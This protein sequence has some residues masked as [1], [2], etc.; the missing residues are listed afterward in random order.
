MKKFVILAAKVNLALVF[1]FGVFCGQAGANEPATKPLRASADIFSCIGDDSIVGSA[2]LRES[3]S[4][5]GIK[6]VDIN[7]IVMG[8]SE[9]QHAVHIHQTAACEISCGATQGHFD[10]GPNSNTNPDGNH[11][12]H[13][14]DLVN[15]EV[16]RGVGVM[17]TRT[18]RITL[19]PGPLSI[20]DNDG[21]AFIIHVNPDTY[22]PNGP[23]AGCA[24]GARAAC[25]NIYLD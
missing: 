21:S 7:M 22:C 17:R 16:N 5:E 12:F 11:P 6:Q 4:T 25:G 3:K 10:P 20:F 19:S 8:L 15:I 18:N 1:L 24:G 23:E 2:V 13:M 9:G 14:G